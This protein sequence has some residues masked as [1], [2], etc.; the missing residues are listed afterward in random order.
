MQIQFISVLQSAMTV[1]PGSYRYH[2]IT[3]STNRHRRRRRGAVYS[4]LLVAAGDDL[5]YSALWPT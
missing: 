1:R 2:Y 3:P 5:D 4:L